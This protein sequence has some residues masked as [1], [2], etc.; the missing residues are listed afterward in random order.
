MSDNIKELEKVPDEVVSEEEVE[1][2]EPVKEEPKKEK[3]P[4]PPKEQFNVMVGVGAGMRLKTDSEY[5]LVIGRNAGRHVTTAKRVII[6]GDDEFGT[7]DDDQFLIADGMPTV[8]DVHLMRFLQ[9]YNE[10]VDKVKNRYKHLNDSQRK[11][12][13]D[14]LEE[15]CEDVMHRFNLIQARLSVAAENAYVAATGTARVSKKEVK[16][17]KAELR[18]EAKAAKDETKSE[19]KSESDEEAEKPLPPSRNA[20]RAAVRKTSKN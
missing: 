11:A 1:E 13:L 2:T 7:N 10:I 12:V 20:K 8:D 4:K 17:A 16:Q 14:K 18:A 6:I 5:C 15:L 9:V 3:K 19:T